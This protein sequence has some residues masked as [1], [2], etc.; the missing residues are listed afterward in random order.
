MR[1]CHAVLSTLHCCSFFL[2]E[3]DVVQEYQCEFHA[4]K[5]VAFLYL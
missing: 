1:I 2:L 3:F 5:K 4:E